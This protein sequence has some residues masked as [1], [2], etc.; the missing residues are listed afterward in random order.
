[1][2][3]PK[4]VCLQMAILA[5]YLRRIYGTWGW[6]Q[7]DS[8]TDNHLNSLSLPAPGVSFHDRLVGW[9]VGSY[10]KV[11]QTVDGGDTW[12][13]QTVLG[14]TAAGGEVV[15]R[16]VQALTAQKV[17]VVGDR[18]TLLRTGDAGRSWE[19][20]ASRTAESLRAVHFVNETWGWVVGDLNDR[21]LHTK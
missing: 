16:G 7:K 12:S 10:G 21:V 4:R 5:C 14:M 1:M 6:E 13:P 8:K 19:L 20:A 9:L 3:S 17:V 18:G 11:L 15:L 2:V